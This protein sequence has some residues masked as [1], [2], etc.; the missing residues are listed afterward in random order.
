M[1][2]LSSPLLGRIHP[3][4]RRTVRA[5]AHALGCFVLKVLLR[6]ERAMLASLHAE[7]LDQCDATEALGGGMA[8]ASA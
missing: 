1:G 7:L 4:A 6:G 5:R 8:S 2:A 3:T